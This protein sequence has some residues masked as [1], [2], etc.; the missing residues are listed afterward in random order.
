VLEG[1]PEIMTETGRQRLGVGESLIVPPNKPHTFEN[2]TEADA[3]VISV[4][5][6]PGFER[7]FLD[8]GV[9]VDA[10][11]VREAR[12][13]RRSSSA[14]NP[15][16]HAMGCIF[17]RR[18]IKPRNSGGLKSQHPTDVNAPLF[19]GLIKGKFFTHCGIRGVL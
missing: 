5:S 7:Y 18:R 15:K 17:S 3:R 9:L 14:S 2:A 8:M 12:K 6:P 19:R 4:Y 11:N 16:R 1:A 13:T 10:P